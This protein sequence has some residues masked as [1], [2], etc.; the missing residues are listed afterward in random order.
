MHSIVPI[1]AD[2]KHSVSELLQR[3]GVGSTSA[4]TPSVTEGFKTFLDMGTVADLLVGYGFAL[5]LASAIAWHPKR[6]S[7]RRA[8]RLLG[9]EGILL[10][11][12]LIGATVALLVMVHPSLGLVVFGIGGLVRFRTT[13]DDPELTS[14]GIVTLV[15]GLACGTGAYLPATIVAVITW[16]LVWFIDNRAT[17]RV[18][19]GTKGEARRS[20]NNE[21]GRLIADIVRAERIHVVNSALEARKNRLSLHLRAPAHLDEAQIL[22]AVKSAL[23]ADV[24]ASKVRIELI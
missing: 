5:L 12:G 22:A 4:T 16:A 1:L 17:Y 24:A 6:M 21:D 3:F 18:R 13:L 15:I 7:V 10:L 9:R 19:I 14:K 2:D 23:P 8:D 11:L 20:L